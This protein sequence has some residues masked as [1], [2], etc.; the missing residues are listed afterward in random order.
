MTNSSGVGYFCRE[1][2]SPGD[3]GKCAADILGDIVLNQLW[4]RLQGSRHASVLPLEKAVMKREVSLSS[5]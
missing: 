5:S 2:S 3:V 4:H 1:G